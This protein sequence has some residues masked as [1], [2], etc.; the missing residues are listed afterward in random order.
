VNRRPRK[1]RIV[2]NVRGS[3]RTAK[4]AAATRYGVAEY[5]LQLSSRQGSDITPITKLRKA[6]MPEQP[7]RTQ[8]R[9]PRIKRRVDLGGGEA[10]CM[11]RE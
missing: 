2:A 3:V 1:K 8:A 9:L 4:T 5:S 10:H 11:V 7:A 6:T